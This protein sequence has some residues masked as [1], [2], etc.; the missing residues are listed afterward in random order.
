MGGT[1]LH[2]FL[3]GVAQV[4]CVHDREKRQVRTESDVAALGLEA[5]IIYDPF[6][7]KIHRCTCCDNLFVDPSDEP[8]Y[9]TVCLGPLVHGLG[10]PLPLPGGVVDG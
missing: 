8:R 3:G 5:G 6:F 4:Y 9:C 7:H 2:P 10:G 1:T